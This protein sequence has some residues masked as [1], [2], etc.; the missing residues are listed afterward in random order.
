M[1]VRKE[2]FM[3]KKNRQY[4]LGGLFIIMAAFVL[5]LFNKTSP[6]VEV[7]K[8]TLTY[9]QQID[10]HLSETIT[11]GNYTFD[12]PYLILN[13][14]NSSPLTALLAF[15]TDESVSATV[16]ISGKDE[17][18]T[19]THSFESA[20]THLIPIYGLYANHLNQV[21]IT[22]SDGR[23]KEVQIQTD[24]LPEDFSL[25]TSVFAKKEKLSN[26]L[27][28]VTPSSEGYTAA[29]DVN[30]DVRWYLTTKNIWDIKRLSNGNLL[31]SSDRLMALPYYMVGLMEMDLLGKVYTEYVF[32]GGYHH[33]AIELPNGNLL[34]AG[35][36]PNKTTVEDYVIELDRETGDVVKSWDLSTILPTEAAKSE[37]WTE[38]DWFHNNSVD[39]DETNQAIILSGRHQDAVISMDYESGQL[40]WIV[41][42]PTGWP[43]EMKPYFFTPTKDPFEWQ[44]SQHSAKILPHQNLAIFDNGNNRSKDPYQYLSANDNYSRGIVYHLNTD[45]MTIEQVFEFGKT[46]GS[47]FYSPYISEIDYLAPDHYL[48]HSGGIGTINGEALNQPAYFYEN[49]ILSSRTV[50][51]LNQERIFELELPSHYY[52]ASK[53]SLYPESTHYNLELGKRLGSLGET[54]T[55]AEKVSGLNFNQNQLDENYQIKFTQESDRLIMTGAFYEGEKVKLI[56][57]RL[58]DQRVYSIRITNTPY[59]AMCVDLFN[60]EAFDDKERLAVTQ[61]VNA[62]GLTGTYE[63]YLDINHV[64]YPLNQSVT[65]D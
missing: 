5:V 8:D 21:T 36:N 12:N 64:V 52:R 30:G 20:T 4:L 51:I 35:N 34:V 55:I 14:Y 13:P 17:H 24:P 6:S 45:A 47:S 61:F 29:Y 18:S 2:F 57:N 41:G 26:D 60:P 23:K 33:D 1:H 63:I 49:A 39:F 48:V 62:E 59:S 38:H 53:L 3:N 25:P 44:W 32:E 40:N 43:E 27:Y 19:F 37:N 58:G 10:T 31:L 22:L 9:Q 54:P 46:E 15:K 28:F 50:E 65:F 11:N 16:T 56:L 42:D 7:V